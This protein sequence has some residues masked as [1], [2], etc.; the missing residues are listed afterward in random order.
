MLYYDQDY[1]SNDERFSV[2]SMMSDQLWEEDQK[3]SVLE[4]KETE[5]LTC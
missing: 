1:P 4:S 2:F 5:S 3:L